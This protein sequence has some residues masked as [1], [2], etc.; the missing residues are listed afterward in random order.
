MG[1]AFGRADPAIRSS[2]EKSDLRKAAPSTKAVRA[3]LVAGLFGLASSGYAAA[4]EG[5]APRGFRCASGFVAK[6]EAAIAAYRE[7]SKAPG[8]AVAFFDQ[9]KACI[10]VSGV[11]NAK[12]A[13][14]VTPKTLFAMGSIQKVFNAT[15]LAY[16]IAQDK[17]AIDDPA[18]KYLVAANGATVGPES[19]IGRCR[20]RSSPS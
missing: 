12:K 13:D 4:Q 17:A 5:A 18:A 2:N 14:P 6:A 10:F 11:K 15:L 19:A 20:R 8:V 7:K 16:A 1:V 3:A 9:G